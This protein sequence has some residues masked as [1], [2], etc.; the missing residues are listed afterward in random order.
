TNS[1]GPT[2]RKEPPEI[3]THHASFLVPLIN[4]LIEEIYGVPAK[5]IWK[6]LGQALLRKLM[7]TTSVEA[8]LVVNWLQSHTK[9]GTFLKTIYLQQLPWKDEWIQ[10]IQALD[11]PADFNFWRS[12]L[13]SSSSSNLNS[14]HLCYIMNTNYLR[15]SGN[16]LKIRRIQRRVPGD[17]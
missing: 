9:Y 8:T 13:S 17:V 15:A 4:A 3:F 7:T 12:L 11:T 16:D 14:I 6:H 10:T 5:V 2:V 1:V